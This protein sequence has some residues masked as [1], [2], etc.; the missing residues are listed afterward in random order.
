MPGQRAAVVMKKY[1]IGLCVISV[2]ATGFSALNTYRRVVNTSFGPGEHL[3]YR[4]H[5]GFLNAA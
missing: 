4:V 2:L 3:E 1:L 5:Y